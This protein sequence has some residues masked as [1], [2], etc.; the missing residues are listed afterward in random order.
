MAQPPT[1]PEEAVKPMR[2]ELTV[3]GCEELKSPEDVDRVL[4]DTK[5]T[6]LVMINSVCGCAA[7][8]ARPGLALALQHKVIP[9]RLATAF[10]GMERDA[11]DR[12]R[13][14]H[15]GYPPSSPSIVLLKDGKLV[16]MVQRSDIEVRDARQVAELLTGIFDQH[17]TRSGPSI[18]PEEFAKLSHA[19]ICGSQLP[20]I[21]S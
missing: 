16:H 20:R 4:N 3:V 15:E 5:G 17:C 11:V 14:L 12:V 2:E 8:N 21:D 1:Y 13:A 18:P 6:V 7:G 9:D 19:K 10:A